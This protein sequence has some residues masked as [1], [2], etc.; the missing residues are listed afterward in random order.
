MLA[1]DV[2]TVDVHDVSQVLAVLDV[3]SDYETTGEQLTDYICSHFSG[4]LLSLRQLE[5]FIKE[6]KR[7]FKTLPRK[8]GV[9][10]E[11]K[12]ISGHRSFKSWCSVLNRSDRA[13]RYMLAKARPEK[14]KKKKDVEAAETISAL[15]DRLVKYVVRNIETLESDQRDC[16]LEAIIKE[17]EEERQK[18]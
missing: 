7:R 13:V 9:D 8:R 12:T 6:I 1:T 16:A 14:D 3:R 15:S 10:G 17:L 18:V 5:P 2:Q 11:Y 4:S